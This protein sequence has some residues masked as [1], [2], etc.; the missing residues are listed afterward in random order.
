MLEAKQPQETSNKLILFVST[1]LI[2]NKYFEWVLDLCR[3]IKEGRVQMFTI[4]FG[5]RI[6]S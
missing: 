5:F 1:L 2:V 6:V 4:L 3:T